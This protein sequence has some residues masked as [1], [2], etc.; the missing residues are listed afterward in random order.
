VTR[1]GNQDCGDDDVI[2]LQIGICGD[3]TEQV[4]TWAAAAIGGQW[5]K[6][7]PVSTT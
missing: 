6:L 5:K 4:I 1:D 2:A 3:E 7:M